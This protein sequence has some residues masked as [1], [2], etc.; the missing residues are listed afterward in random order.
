MADSGEMKP[1]APARSPDATPPTRR[2]AEE[3]AFWKQALTVAAGVGV[4]A[5]G[6]AFTVLR[7]FRKRP[8]I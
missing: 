3:K 1:G 2:E 5:A 7:I 6:V 8:R 4:A